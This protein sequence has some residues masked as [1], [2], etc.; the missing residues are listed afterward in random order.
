MKSRSI[1]PLAQRTLD[2]AQRHDLLPRGCRVLCALSGGV[3]SMALLTLL[4][5]LR[6]PLELE[7]CAAHFDHQLRGAASQSDGD[8]VEDWCASHAIPLRRGRGDVAGAARRLHQGLEETG[9]QL[10]YA[11][12]EESAQ[13][14][15]AQV[16]ATAHH[17]GDNAE[18]VLLHLLRGTGLDGL[19]GIPPK[20][21][22]LIRPLLPLTREELEAYLTARGIPHVEDASNA[23][24]RYARNRL[25]AQV[26]PVLQALNPGFLPRLTANL[27]YLQAERDYLG[28][29]AAAL[30]RKARREGDAIVL[31]AQTLALA[32]RPL[33]LRA[34][35][36]L[37]RDLGQYQLSAVHLE[38]V[39]A[40]TA[41]ETK[42]AA[43]RSLPGTIQ[44]RRRYGDLVLTRDPPPAPL[45]PL[46]IPGPGRWHFGPWVLELREQRE[47]DGEGWRFG[48][49]DFP[50][51]LR[52]RA[53]GD[54]LTLPGRH[55]KALK[56]WYIDEKIPRSL[57]DSLPVLTDR[58]GILAAAGLGP[59]APRLSPEGDFF[60][61]LT[62]KEERTEHQL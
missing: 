7:V 19:C 4:L 6:D 17:A 5:E 29:Q 60:L 8:F 51:T 33:A 39:L 54:R 41:P 21:G 13:A 55:S 43:A 16:I 14:L 50:L 57:R 38:A 42:P 2:F 53:P 48:P 32:P 46:T 47:D 34:L 31:P 37:F 18:T 28:A 20:R 56:K 11:F 3:D 22:R 10:R 15:S 45:P 23:D 36:Q 44:A 30:C 35:R 24:P 58:Q 25:R 49:L 40:L 9:R 12:L 27:E 52:S 26:L 1:D 59:H 61:T 62:N